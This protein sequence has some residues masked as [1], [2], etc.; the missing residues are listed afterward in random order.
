LLQL[1]LHTASSSLQLRLQQ[2]S[3]LKPQNNL[4]SL[5]PLL[6]RFSC[7]QLAAAAAACSQVATPQLLQ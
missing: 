2:K 4:I 7:H 6:P 3:G 5:Q 1:L